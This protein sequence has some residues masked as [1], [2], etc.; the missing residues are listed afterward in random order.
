MITI[1][2]TSGSR[3][4]IITTSPMATLAKYKLQ[5]FSVASYVISKV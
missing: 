3:I 4:T 2:L 1:T 5:G